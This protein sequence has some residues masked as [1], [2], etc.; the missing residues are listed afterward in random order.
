M[1][2]YSSCSPLAMG[3]PDI[4]SLPVL[5]IGNK[6]GDTGYIDFIKAAD[7]EHPVMR[8][9]D[10]YGRPFIAIKVK[11]EGRC[12]FR[13]V[14]GT[15]FQRY[16]DCKFS[17]AYGT[18]YHMNMIYHDSRIRPEA[19]ADLTKRLKVLTSGGEIRSMDFSE[20]GDYVIG[21]G[22]IVMKL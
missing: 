8:G 6:V 5:D 1:E 2:D 20:S 9:K 10:M 21:A 12:P 3:I 15:F 13:E 14:V 18:C 4:E 19:E 16:D 17:W 11:A 7:M 22:P